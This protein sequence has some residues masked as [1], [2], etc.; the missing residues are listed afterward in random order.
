M[1][2]RLPGPI[3]NQ[4]AGLSLRGNFFRIMS[5]WTSHKLRKTVLL[6]V[7]AMISIVLNQHQHRKWPRQQFLQQPH[8][9][10]ET[11]SLCSALTVRIT[12]PSLLISTVNIKH[13]LVILNSFCIREHERRLYIGIWCCYGSSFW[14]CSDPEEWVLVLWRKFIQTPGKLQ[15]MLVLIFIC[16]ISG[17]QNCWMQAWT[18]V[19]LDL[20]FLLRG[21]QYV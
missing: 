10:L 8:H 11:R 6:D 1:W 12:N 14:L 16:S 4:A 17:K 9:Q 19:G 13:Y 20:R 18:S 7:R 5:S 2:R 21:M 3:Q 15:K